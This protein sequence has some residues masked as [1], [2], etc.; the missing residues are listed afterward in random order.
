MHQ[1]SLATITE[2]GI[3]FSVDI[4]NPLSI[5]EGTEVYGTYYP[6][7]PKYGFSETYHDIVLTPIPYQCWPFSARFRIWLKQEVPSG[8]YA[9]TNIFKENGMSIISTDASRS[10]H[11]YATCTVTVCVTSLMHEYPD[12]IIDDIGRL[13]E[14]KKEMESRVKGCLDTLKEKCN[15]YL[16]SSQEALGLEDSA[17]GERL[18]ALSYFYER[19]VIAKKEGKTDMH[20]KPWHFTYKKG[21][22]MPGVQTS[23]FM[24]SGL[25]DALP[26]RA[27]AEMNTRDANIRLAIIRTNELR[28]FGRVTFRY[29]WNA[30][31]DSCYRKDS[32]GEI[33][34]SCGIASNLNKIISQDY[35]IWRFLDYV[36]TME[37]CFEEGNIEFFLK[38]NPASNVLSWD[39]LRKRL[40][41]TRLEVPGVILKNINVSPISFMRVF[42]STRTNIEKRRGLRSIC[43]LVGSQYGML[44]EDFRIVETYTRGVIPSVVK[45][46][47]NA[48]AMIQYYGNMENDPNNYDWLHAELLAA[49]VLDMPV[50]AIVEE[51]TLREKIKTLGDRAVLKIPK[52]PSDADVSEAISIALAE[53]N[54]AHFE[55]D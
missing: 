26:S 27:F 6:T 32:K 8:L 17:V 7:P 44:E 37:P 51:G 31:N 39:L 49:Q 40:E 45:E 41:S 53:I 11:R 1:S 54:N 13:A 16:F 2:N 22:L 14:I 36:N 55:L 23:S 33:Q 28:E 50:V 43:T 5:R 47:R 48:H 3:K 29:T 42:L 10:G 18:D 30:A 52:D 25:S 20:W 9:V 35:N 12:Q 46:I 21:V 38:R 24:R 15:K 4:L 34:S 19:T